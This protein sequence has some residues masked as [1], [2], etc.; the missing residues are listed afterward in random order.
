MSTLFRA[1]PVILV[2]LMIPLLN[3]CPAA[4]DGGNGDGDG[5]GTTPVAKT[6]QD[7]WQTNA[8]GGTSQDFSESPVP[9]GFF[10]FGGRS[11]EAFDGAAGFVGTAISEGALGLADTIVSRS[12][13]PITPSDPVGTVNSVDVEIT[14]LSMVSVE[15]ITV[16]CDGG[17]TQWDVF[18]G[19]S[20]TPPPAGTLTA[21]KDHENGGT[22]ETVLYVLP[23]L[24]FTNVDDPT[25]ERVLDLGEEGEGPIELHATIPWVHA[26]NPADPDPGA[27]FILGIDG[28]AGVGKLAGEDFSDPTTMQGGT[29]IAC[30]EHFNPSGSH[31]HNTCVV[32]TDDDG[33]TDGTDNCRFAPNFD[34]EDSDGDT[35]GDECDPCPDDP[36]CPSGD[37]EGRCQDLL[38]TLCDFMY[39][40][41]DCDLW[42][43]CMAE[44][45]ECIPPDCI[46]TETSACLE[47]AEQQSAAYES[48]G[49]ES[50]TTIF[51]D[52][53]NEGCD[54]CDVRTYELCEVPDCLEDMGG[55]VGLKAVLKKWF[56]RKVHTRIREGR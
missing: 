23:K 51:E 48:L 17:P 16:S 52:F 13:D 15:S 21:T 44:M 5:N 49:D 53:T 35:F 55:D 20:D 38:T 43:A 40:A 46:P 3:G 29:L 24:I 22:A 7:Y 31:L 39:A 34:Q 11:C 54:R 9:A 4:G 2:S 45:L 19:L 33:I 47:F 12:E 56:P 6:P 14:A 18:V 28:G 50:V 37:C 10:D 1:I 8:A 26:I 42:E 36:D 27:A 25:V 30:T 32:D 41:F